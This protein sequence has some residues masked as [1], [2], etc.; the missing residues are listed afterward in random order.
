MLLLLAL[1]LIQSL[2]GGHRKRAGSVKSGQRDGVAM[3]QGSQDALSLKDGWPHGLPVNDDAEDPVYGFPSP[4]PSP[5]EWI[6]IPR[7][8]ALGSQDGCC[9]SRHP[10]CP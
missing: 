2:S 6:L 4:L 9:S 7:L 5:L 10:I 1:P 3:S 8:V